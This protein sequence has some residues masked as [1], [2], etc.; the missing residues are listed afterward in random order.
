[1]KIEEVARVRKPKFLKTEKPNRSFK[2]PNGE[3]EV[4]INNEINENFH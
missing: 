3:S 4:K 1:M 2:K